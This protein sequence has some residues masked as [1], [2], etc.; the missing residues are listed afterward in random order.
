MKKQYFSVRTDGF[1]GAYY[2]NKN[3]SDMAFIVMLGDNVDDFLA[4]TAVKW[5]HRKGFNCLAMSR[6]KNDY[7]H[8]N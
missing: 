1:Y 8:Y 3:P 6:T 7:R 5:L 2:K 4:K